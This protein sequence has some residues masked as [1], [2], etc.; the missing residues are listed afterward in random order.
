M[1]KESL[2][3]I[4]NLNSN[5]Y[6]FLRKISDNEFSYCRYTLSGDLEDKNT[7]WGLCN[8]VFATKI[9]YMI[10]KLNKIHDKEKE[11]LYQNILKFT[12]KSGYIFDPFITSLSL[13]DKFKRHFS[14]SLNLRYKRIEDIRRA[15]TRQSFAALFLLNKKPKKPFLNIPYTIKGVNKYL[16]SFN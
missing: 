13:Y 7:F 11:N 10:N 2:N 15:E 3:W 6:K 14:K 4:A 12:D 1:D 9:L 8:Y 5:L 16:S